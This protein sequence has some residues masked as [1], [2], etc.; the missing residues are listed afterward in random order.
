VPVVA[1][2]VNRINSLLGKR[3][4]MDVLVE[5]LEQLGCDVEDTAVL[6]LYKCPACQTPNDKLAHE[7]P[8]KRCDFCGYESEVPFEKFATDPVIRLDLLADRP[9]LFD[10]GGLSRALKGYLGIEQGLSEFEVSKGDVVVDVDPRM[11][12]KDTYRPYIAAAVVTMPPIDHNSLREIMRLQENLHWG[13]G[14]DRKLSSIGV[15]DLDTIVSPIKYAPFDPDNFEFCPLGMPGVRMTLRQILEEHPKGK[16][17]AHLM[18]KYKG[19]PILLDANGQVLSMPPIINS[20]ETKL[21]IGS[22][23]LFIDVTGIT[24]DA[25]DDS[26]NT[27]VSAL[28]ELGGKAA[29]VQMNYPDGP[30]WTP[31]LKPGRIDIHYLEAKRWLGLEFTP[32]EFMQYLRKMRLNVSPKQDRVYEV[33]YPVFRT[34]IRHEVDIFEDL[35]IGYG[36][37]RIPLEMVPSLTVG[38]PRPEEVISQTAREI[39]T[40]LGF[41]E[42][43]SLLL[44]SIERHFNKFRLEP[45]DEHVVVENPKTLEQKIARSHMM[46]GIMETF[47][48]NRRKAFPQKI[49]ELGNIILINPEMET[50]VNEYRHLAFGIIGADTGYSEA[51]GI[52]DSI[53]RELGIKCEYAPLDHPSFCE[54]RSAK[55]T[56]NTSELWAVLGEIHPEVLNNFDLAFPVVYCE[57]RLRRVI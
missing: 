9:D 2:S 29:A 52:L 56:G 13:I 19:Y 36:F 39:M 15:Y 49:F 7:D 34:D 14:R 46:T 16:A 26:L 4:E 25:V 54:G 31:D 22:S 41:T 47:Q 27:L 17:Y 3:Y 35:A 21:K 5:A 12:E 42:I 45:E 18:E 40:G 38:E 33:V 50:G 10:A 11:F 51:R 6:A 37:S 57:L 28:I 43:M 23:N 20:E 24:Q 8:P 30:S 32:E 48:K 44:Q 1:I 53:L 55:V